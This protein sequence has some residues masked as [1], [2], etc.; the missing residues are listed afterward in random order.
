MN[1]RARTHL[2]RAPLHAL[3]VFEAAARH[4]SFRTAAAELALTPSA[5]SHQIR[6]LE[7]HL[8]LALF[9]R[10]ARGVDL[11]LD[12]RALALGL[13]RALDEIESSLEALASQTARDDVT[14]SVTPAFAA[15]WL[16]PRL[17]S[18]EQEHPNV[19]VRI[20]ATNEMS[21]VGGAGDV[22][23]AVRY[24]RPPARGAILFEEEFIAVASPSYARRIRDRASLLGVEWRSARFKRYSWEAFFEANGKREFGTTKKGASFEDESHAVLAAVAGQ[25]VA[26]VSRVLVQDLLDRGD[27]VRVS[28]GALPG[29]T[30]HLVAPSD[31]LRRAPVHAFAKWLR[32]MAGLAPGVQARTRAARPRRKL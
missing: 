28:T 17:G 8:G 32:E 3:V 19:T 1:R 15:R 29:E 31:R 6:A 20:L 25:G 16:V 23:L 26:L 24:G 22:D 2:P 10:K 30:Y 13:I 21:V 9:S 11:T 27:L 4:G 12:G 7:D 5:V 14:V 18:F